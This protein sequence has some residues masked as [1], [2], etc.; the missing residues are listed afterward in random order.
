MIQ[1]QIQYVWSF[2][3][4]TCPHVCIPVCVPVSSPVCTPVCAR[5]CTPVCACVFTYVFTCVHVC[6][7]MCSSVCTPV[8][9]LV[10][11]SAEAEVDIGYL[12]PLHISISLLE[13]VSHSTLGETLERLANSKAPGA[14]PL[15]PSVLGL[16]VPG[17]MS[18]FF[19][20]LSSQGCK[21]GSLCLHSRHFTHCTTFP[22]CQ[23][24][25]RI[26]S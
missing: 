10:L 24:S 9:V 2:C 16:Q 12:P 15:C 11:S 25:Q 3:V 8:C 1:Q 7:P 5:M 22:T 6:T 18:A 21:L 17:S 19:L 20:L 14:A 4:C 13:A 26:K 23:C